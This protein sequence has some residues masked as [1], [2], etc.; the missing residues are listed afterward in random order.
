MARVNTP[1]QYRCSVCSEI[2]HNA[3]TCAKRTDGPSATQMMKEMR[4]KKRAEKAAI[5]AT[6]IAAAAAT[7]EVLGG[8]DA[9]REQIA[10]PTA[11]S[12]ADAVEE[13]EAESMIEETELDEVEPSDEELMALEEEIEEEGEDMDLAAF[14]SDDPALAAMFSK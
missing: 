7:V 14:F 13:T 1:K 8:M 9:I 2:G 6:K 3:R 5:K 11:H 10:A 12:Y 4:A